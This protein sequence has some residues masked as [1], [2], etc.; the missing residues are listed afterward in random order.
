MFRVMESPSF[1]SHISFGAV[2][3]FRKDCG[4]RCRLTSQYVVL[5][6]YMSGRKEKV[7]C[8]VQKRRWFPCKTASTWAFPYVRQHLTVFPKDIEVSTYLAMQKLKYGD[9]AWSE[10]PSILSQRTILDCS[11]TTISASNFC[12]KQQEKRW[13]WWRLSRLKF[14]SCYEEQRLPVFVIQDEK[15]ESKYHAIKG[16]W[17]GAPE[18]ASG[19]PIDPQQVRES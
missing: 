12:I 17:D 19:L 13:F 9:L 14:R 4:L 2:K 16:P 18:S 7:P 3:C 11:G 8:E 1:C 15:R 5:L 10:S 6:L